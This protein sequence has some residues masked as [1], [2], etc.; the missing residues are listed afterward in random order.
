MPSVPIHVRVPEHIALIIDEYASMTE[1]DR[2]KI[3]NEALDVWLQLTKR[4]ADIGLI[5]HTPASFARLY[6]NAP[7][8]N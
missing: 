6:L 5:K 4:F 2:S 7:S 1:S 8:Q 3:V